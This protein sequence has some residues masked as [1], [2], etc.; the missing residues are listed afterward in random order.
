M[1]ETYFDA[2]KF[3]GQDGIYDK[4]GNK[5][6][7]KTITVDDKNVDVCI[8]NT[9]AGDIQLYAYNKPLIVPRIVKK[10]VGGYPENVT[11]AMEFAIYEV[12]T[13]F[14]ATSDAVE[15]LLAGDAEPVYTG[16]TKE[17]TSDGKGSFAEWK[18]TDP[19]KC[20][21]P[22]KTYL[23]V[24][25]LVKAQN[26]VY[27]TMR[28]DREDVKWYRTLSPVA[29]PD[30]SI[31]Y[32][33][34]LDNVYG[35][36][37]VKLA[38]AVVN[39]PDAE[40]TK[41]AADTDNSVVGGKMETLLNGSRK[42]VYK[43]TPVVT[44]HNQAL[45][46]FI[47]ED[48]GLTVAP[49]DAVLDYEFTGLDVGAASHNTESLG[50]DGAEISAK[51][52]FKD[53]SGAEI[54]SLTHA[55]SAPWENVDVPAGT[56]SFTI[57]YYSKSVQDKTK[58]AYALGEEF[59]VSPITVYA[60]VKK[61]A[62]GTVEDP[63]TE[64]ASFT[65]TAKAVLNYPKWKANGSGTEDVEKTSSDT[66]KVEVNTIARPRVQ[67]TKSS[68]PYTA[69]QMKGTVEYTITLKNLGEPA[70]AAVDFIN[71]VVLDMLPTDVTYVANS[72]V[73]GTGTNGETF[74]MRV[75]RRTGDP[76]QT[77]SVAGGNVVIGAP[78]TA[79]IFELT[80]HLEPGSIVTI[81]FKAYVGE[82][83]VL[84]GGKLEN[85]VFLSSAYHTCHTK[86]NP[87]GY[88]FENDIGEFPGALPGEADGLSTTAGT[89]EDGLHEALGSYADAGTAGYIWVKAKT[90]LNVNTQAAI[91][92][93]KAVWG[94]LDKGYND[95][96]AFLGTATR[97]NSA[98]GEETKGWVNWRLSGVNGSESDRTW[99]VMG[100]VIP[101]TTDGRDTKWNVIMD[102]VTG[103]K[104]GDDTLTG[105]SD[106]YVFYYTGSGDSAVNAVNSALTDSNDWLTG[107]STPAW[108][109]AKTLPDNW[110]KAGDYSGDKAD[111]TAFAIVFNSD[112]VLKSGDSLIVTYHTETE[113]ISDDEAF[114]EVAFENANNNFKM[115]WVGSQRPMTSNTVSVT[116]MDDYV[117]VEGDL[118]ID[119]DWDG[120]QE[121]GKADGTKTDNGNHRD[122]S[123]YA[124]VKKL[125]N[126]VSF[127]IIDNRISSGAASTNDKGADVDVVRY[128]ES[129][130]HFRFENLG[131]AHYKGGIEK[132][133]DNK[134]NIASLKT[135]D[136]YN[137]ILEA[138]ISDTSL[139]DIFRI[140]DLGEGYYKSDDPDDPKTGTAAY[141]L[142]NNFYADSTNE[143]LFITQPFYICYSAR[144]DQSKDIGFK[145]LRDLEITKVAA[146]DHTIKLEG[147]EFEIYG[148]FHEGQGTCASG[149]PLKFTEVR[150]D[151]GKVLSYTY[152][153]NGTV[154]TLKT[155]DNGKL[156][157]T[158]LNWWK[159]YVIKETESVEGYVIAGAAAAADASA[160][161]EVQN[162]GDGLW[163]LKIPSKDKLSKTDKVTVENQ[164]EQLSIEKY[165][166]EDVHAEIEGFNKVFTYDIITYV[167]K[168][169]VNTVITDSLVPGLK[170]VTDGD[171]ITVKDIGTD[172]PDHIAHG[173]VSAIAGTDV[174]KDET[175]TS[176][177]VD[178]DNKVLTVKIADSRSLRGHWVK[179][180]FKT[181]IDDTV[182]KNQETYEDNLEE[183]KENITDRGLPIISKEYGGGHTGIPNRA[184]YCIA[185]ENGYTYDGTYSN[186]VTVTPPVTC[187]KVTKKWMDGD[188]PLD[189][190]TEL[191]EEGN[192]VEVPVTFTLYRNEAATDYSVILPLTDAD[193]GRNT[194]SYVFTGLPVYVDVDNNDTPYTYTVKESN[195]P[196]AYESAGGNHN[197]A[198]DE[199]KQ[200][201]LEYVFTVT[202]TVKEEPAIAKAVNK[203]VHAQLGAFDEVYTYD[204]VAYI[205]KDASEAEI[206]DE[207]AAGVEFVSAAGEVT[208]SDLGE[209]VDYKAGD[210]GSFGEKQGIAFDAD[211]L[212]TTETSVTISG[213]KL[214][215]VM[216]NAQNLRG[217]YVKVTF[218]ARIDNDVVKNVESYEA[219]KETVAE[220]GLV[221]S[222]VKTHEGILNRANYSII[223]NNGKTY[224]TESNSVTVTPATTEITVTK[225]WN[226]E[227]D[228][229]L[230]WPAGAAVVVTLF[231]DNTATDR[232]VTLTAEE[233]SA[234]FKNLPVYTTVTY[235]VRESG[236]S[237]VSANDYSSNISGN[238]SEGYVILNKKR[239]P[240]EIPKTGDNTPIG[241]WTA[242]AGLAAAFF[243]I[244]AVSRRRYKKRKA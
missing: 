235:S 6:E 39:N 24:E 25:T 181:V 35:E 201:G 142:D 68:V 110:V 88:S 233:S 206:N 220:N 191:D 170:F 95:S 184:S 69:V 22:T 210:D 36:A 178:T 51:I 134:L 60:T 205:T 238:A 180:T 183:V 54:S 86:D 213:K 65:N 152:D 188:M 59:A 160:G 162:L 174:D 97:T 236:V 122:Y 147:V 49:D 130:R 81:T 47:I 140:T 194:Y 223:A 76:T 84:Y 163:T 232:T 57:E 66:A 17:K 240:T 115:N 135:T 38:K 237:G 175:E 82:G 10:D 182:V 16:E 154:T 14:N 13:G 230:P 212:K 106:Y 3:I 34:E 108:P 26:G 190:P 5:L 63:V 114:A 79:V 148:P 144:V 116:L 231:S 53:A 105:N 23:L 202:N 244:A 50:I 70:S 167:T 187:V 104:N 198:S 234:V 31:T 58:S 155:D 12:D 21:D 11:A 215:V 94:N 127:D 151:D 200:A 171:E 96:D 109:I 193:E 204:I 157:V 137:Y 46:S 98:P 214:S 129:I 216:G 211:R 203:D 222:D 80:G 72:A 18:D 217:H 90:Q 173:S 118:W 64:V 41:A 153:E 77:I 75:Q 158:G 185:G 103:V 91:T 121:Y 1:A 120:T 52:S 48:S 40:N 239:P 159:E 192:T 226:D 9:G 225:I 138:K 136:P 15:K 161:T 146:E 168:D 117:A 207:L 218:N 241:L 44:S 123:E 45:A 89:R 33:F 139:L 165:V 27:D 166:N 196:A 228:N 20:W 56:R 2:N 19:A 99:L 195:V 125:V 61:M 208:V 101:K 229:V 30:P 219:N 119:E 67:V 150:D 93:K 227:K 42:V 176:I 43:L 83:A 164:H 111:I 242:V 186:T 87:Y 124:I 32:E 7:V 156:T 177:N 224:R 128:G 132:Y 189:W 131:A 73:V 62:D 133:I 141:M 112:I 113:D 243:M 4:D 143:G 8:V 74:Q 149:D 209:K 85:D 199:E 221:T 197:L 100:D 102:S 55:V 169:A 37:S 29:D 92:L 179:V 78:E 28:K 71:P 145:M 126:S 172:E 107:S